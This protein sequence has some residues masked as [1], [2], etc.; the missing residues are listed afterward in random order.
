M[1]AEDKSLSHLDHPF[2]AASQNLVAQT[3]PHFRTGAIASQ[4]SEGENIATGAASRYW[5][6]IR[7]DATGRRI[8]EPLASAKA[9]FL[10]SF[11]DYLPQ[12]EVPHTLIQ[13]QLLHWMREGTEQYT[14]LQSTHKKD[15]TSTTVSQSDNEET[16]RRLLA[17]LCLKCFISSQIDRICQQL[18][19]RFGELHGFTRSDLLRYVLDEDSNRLRRNATT[20]ISMSYQS[21]SQEILQ[22]FNPE[23]SGL[24]TWTTRLVKHHRELNA[25]LLEHGVY[26]ISDWAILNDTSSKQLQR[27]FSEFHYQTDAEIQQAKQLLECYHAVYRAER[28][29][30]RQARTKGHCLPPTREQLQQIAQRLSTQI[31]EKYRLETVMTK[32]QEM[33]S[34]LREYRIY[35]RGGSMPTESIDAPVTNDSSGNRSLSHDLIDERNATDEQTEFLDSYRQQFHDCLDQAI[36]IVTEKRVTK[37]ERKESQKAQTFIRALQLFHCKELSMGEI[38][39]ELNLQAQYHVSRL[40]NLKSFRADVQQ[41]CLVLLRDR[42]MEEA[43]AYTSPEH[44]QAFSHQIEEALNEQVTQLIQ[45]ATVEASTAVSRRNPSTSRSLFA[46]RLCHYLDIR[47]SQAH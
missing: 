7:L 20:S 12:A 24:A 22:S 18:A 35:R 14:D 6:L 19:A 28:L 11:P 34:R 15:I 41:E 37:L 36:A 1:W 40:L 38:A 44:L 43:K 45:E 31:G 8:S 3:S 21:L 9:F 47:S 25:V 46:E 32:L 26:L 33:A 16:N 39:K 27:I 13:R 17:E 2:V 29:Q 5:T 10:T 4:Q 30:Q 23:Q 42:V